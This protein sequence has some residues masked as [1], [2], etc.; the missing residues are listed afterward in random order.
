MKTE[1][2]CLRISLFPALDLHERI[3]TECEVR[4]AV[5]FRLASSFALASELVLIFQKAPA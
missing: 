2:F 1:T 4:S 5:G 3:V